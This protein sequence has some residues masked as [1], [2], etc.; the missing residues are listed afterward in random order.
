MIY[1]LAV[2]GLLLTGLAGC[3]TYP[4][5]TPVGGASA[6]A[7]PLDTYVETNEPAKMGDIAFQRGYFG[8]SERYYREAVEKTPGDVASWIALGASYD[9][10]KRFD[11]ADR[12]YA[13]ARELGGDS[14]ALLN[15]RGYSY[16]LRGKFREADADFR[17]ALRLDPDNLVVQNNLALLQQARTKY[18]R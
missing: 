10:L 3:Q 17:K 12:A 7:T 18:R 9:N 15:N 1:R 8:L 11:L 4:D 13:R 2:A 6:T 14:V 5:G 16:M